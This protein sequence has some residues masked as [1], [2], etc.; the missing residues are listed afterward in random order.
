MDSATLLA[1]VPLLFMAGVIAVIVYGIVALTRR[2]S[3][4]PDLDP[5]I[6]TVRRLYF[7]I[8]SFA[9][10]TMATT[11]VV[12]LGVAVLDAIFGGAAVSGSS[13]GVAL[14]I[15]LTV[16]G[17]PLWW[18]H[19][20]TVTRYVA[21]MP[22][23]RRS[24]F[25]KAYIYLVLLTSIGFVI[26]TGVAIVRFLF[27]GTEF[28]AFPWAAFVVW[29]AVWFFHM[30]LEDAEGQPTPETLAVRRLYLYIVAAGTL[31][32]AA[33]GTALVIHTIL[34]DAYD[35]VTGLRVVGGGFW[36]DSFK[37]YLA[38][39][40][41]NWPAWADHWLHRARG[42]YDSTLRQVYLYLLAILGGLLTVIIAVGVT[43]YGL[44]EWVVGVPELPAADHFRFLSG[45]VASV[46]VGAG[47]LVYHAMV[48]T[49]EARDH[50]QPTQ[51]ARQSYAYLLAAIGLFT[52]AT[53]IMNLTGM[54]IRLVTE[55]G[56]GVITGADAWRDALDLALTLG[57]IGGPLWGFYWRRARLKAEAVGPAER[58]SQPRRMFIFLVLGAGMLAFLGSVSF[59]L[60]VI[61]REVLEGTPSQILEGAQ[62]ALSLL[63]PV[64]I[65][66]PYYWMVYREDRRLAPEETEVAERPAR[67]QVS[68]LVAEG[69]G[70]F[71]AALEAAL[72]YGVTTLRW[73][74]ADAGLAEGGADAGAVAE[75][76]AAAAGE[77]VLVI[78]RGDRVDV[79]SYR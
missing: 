14:G 38:I 3:E 8:V 58:N 43:V 6:G 11:G 21:T 76:V 61:L 79:V 44:L 75:R 70:P 5:G 47:I 35:A 46:I 57:I 2:R 22:A 72:G 78:A 24:V 74:D 41:V 50:P 45:T 65:F 25:R 73:A 10:L 51:S 48:A 18:F 34:R 68:V 67:K 31:A 9:A 52:L 16:V 19:W 77:R 36:N 1:L 39:A 59:F 49:T 64:A 30:R 32:A 71:V 42:D 28:A 27:G 63:A 12:L 37:T 20:R 62:G 56:D 4:A 54:F 53:G 69:G 66:L 23:E 40:L 15:A 26:G 33:T 55:S 7:Y 13:E 29:E 17:L 60:F